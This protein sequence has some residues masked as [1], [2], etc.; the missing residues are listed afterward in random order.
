MLII[1][2]AH[3]NNCIHPIHTLKSYDRKQH[4]A[5]GRNIMAMKVDF[6]CK[7]G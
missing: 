7:S 6:Y 3:H 1:H 5:E 2:L 4:I